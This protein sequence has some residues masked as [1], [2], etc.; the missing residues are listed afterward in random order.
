MRKQHTSLVLGVMVIFAAAHLA[1]AATYTWI[2]GGDPTNWEDTANWQGGAVIPK[3]EV[4]ADLVFGPATS[5]NIGASPSS[6]RM[7][8]G[9]VSWESNFTLRDFGS[10]TVADCIKVDTGSPANAMATISNNAHL[11][12][13]YATWLLNSNLELTGSGRLTVNAHNQNGVRGPGGFIVG[14]GTRL[15]FVRT[16]GNSQYVYTGGV[17]IKNGGIVDT[18]GRGAGH[19]ALGDGLL[20]IEEGGLLRSSGTLDQDALFDINSSGT[21]SP[22]IVGTTTSAT[23]TW[24]FDLADAGDTIGDSWTLFGGTSPGTGFNV[25][26]WTDMGGGLWEG[27]A[28]NMIYAFDIGTG[29]LSVDREIPEP[30]SMAL[31][32]LGA[33]F[34]VRR[35]G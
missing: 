33:L 17:T 18:T 31:L 22:F 3:T 6:A 26:G 1:S 4:D 16:H 32:A 10:Y 9:S 27:P 19:G 5:G 24:T 21:T 12:A 15:Y 34:M 30:A 29:V 35:R 23:G 14:P 25:A 28:N 2:Q 20:T 8:F 7:T 11:N 13:Y